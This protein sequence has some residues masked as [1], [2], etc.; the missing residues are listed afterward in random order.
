MNRSKFSWRD[1]FLVIV[2]SCIVFFLYLIIANIFWNSQRDIVLSSMVRAP[3]ASRNIILVEI[4]KR[5][6]EEF[7]YPLPRDRYVSGLLYIASLGPAVIGMDVLFAEKSHNK[8][9][10]ERLAQAFSQIPNIVLWYEL[11][12]RGARIE[13]GG[14]YALFQKSVSATGYYTVQIAENGKVYSMYPS[15]ISYGT[16]KEKETVFESFSL[17]LLKKYYENLYQTPMM[18]ERHSNFYLL[19]NKEKTVYKKIPLQKDKR[20]HILYSPLEYFQRESFFH[21]MQGKHSPH[22]S[23]KNNIVLIGYNLQGK[24]E[25]NV[26]IL[27][28][29][30]PGMYIHANIINNVLREKYIQYFDETIEMIVAF[31]TIFLIIYTNV[32]Y[33]REK[34][35]LWLVSGAGVILFLVT[36]IYVFLSNIFEFYL[37]PNYPIAFISIVFFSFF[38]SSILKYLNEDKNKRRLFEVL[39]QYVSPEIAREHLEHTGAINLWWEN[40]RITI[41]FSD[42][43]GFTTISEKLTPEEL[44]A[45]LKVYLSAMTEIIINTKGMVNKYE[46]DAIMALWGIFWKTEH[47]GVLDACEA[48][49]LQAKKIQELNTTFEKEWKF[50]IKVRMGLHCGNAVIGDIGMQGKKIE[51]TALGDSVNLA[52]RLEW[53]NKFYNTSICVS[54]SVYTEAKERFMFRYLDTIRVKGKEVGVKIYELLGKMGE[55]EA[56]ILERIALFE[57]WIACYLQRDFQQAKTIFDTCA[58]MGD[59]P[60][61][62]YQKRCEHYIQNP[63]GDT[64]DGIWVFDE[65]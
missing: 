6:V 17:V 9:A 32:F 24:D 49:V 50:P 46:G 38:S 19:Y 58:S 10:D 39:S 4:D 54:E 2:V 51:F 48:C 45:F 64:W 65:K 34:G 21:L 44:V 11:E 57:K 23:F 28:K 22:I 20:F 55:V 53:V 59:G 37:L 31:L 62:T 41:F 56:N 47:Y 8:E 63:P 15:I 36:F 7:W 60:S 42:I 43:A 29:K 18:L 35:L 61:K 40:K 27:E 33:I 26:P 30:I 1:F 16:W 13:P 12:K 5:S 3:L 52:S 14:L 25:F